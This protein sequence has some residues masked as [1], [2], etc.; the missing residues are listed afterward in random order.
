[1]AAASK[2]ARP[3]PSPRLGE[4][5]I[6]VGA[7]MAGLLAARVLADAYDRV[8]VLDRDRLPD[9]LTENRRAVP[10]GRHAHGLQPGGQPALEHLLPGIR[11]EA[12]E[13]GALTLDAALDMRMNVGGNDI[14]RVRLD[15]DYAVASRPMLEG[16]VRR[17]VARSRTSRSATASP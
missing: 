3:A 11:D 4:H 5:A 14:R 10:Q 8:T 12:L 7:S 1:M 6:V 9:G 16:L 15:G 2:P 13:A 17:R